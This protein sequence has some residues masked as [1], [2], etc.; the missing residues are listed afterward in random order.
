MT[1]GQWSGNRRS[2]AR[3]CAMKTFEIQDVRR[4]FCGMTMLMV[5][6][7]RIVV[8][9]KGWM[10]GRFGVGSLVGAITAFEKP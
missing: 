10:Q 8:N 1:I 9:V 6:V 4:S 7:R 5:E 2:S 3:P